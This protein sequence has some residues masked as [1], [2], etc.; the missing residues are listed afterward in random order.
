MDAAMYM[1]I[2]QVALLPSEYHSEYTVN[3]TDFGG[4]MPSNSSPH[5][6]LDGMLGMGLWAGLFTFLPAAEPLMTLK[7]YRCF[8][9]PQDILKVALNV[10][11]SPF[12]L[13]LSVC[14]PNKLAVPGPSVCPTQ[15]TSALQ[16]CAE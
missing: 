8:I 10:D 5:M 6:L 2:L 4:S 12:Q 13:F 3:N 7:L 11:T 16:Y 14:L 15:F 9:C 1:R